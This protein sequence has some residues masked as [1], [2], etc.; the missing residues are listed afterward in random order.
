LLDC[1]TENYEQNYFAGGKSAS[2]PLVRSF[3]Q[4]N[5]NSIGSE[6]NGKFGRGRGIS[7]FGIQRA[8]GNDHFGI[9]E[10]KEGLKYLCHPW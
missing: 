6:K 9:S 4:S 2:L 10:G 1:L 7:D 8:W 3:R 5:R